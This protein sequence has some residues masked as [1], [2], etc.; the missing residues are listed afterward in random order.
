MPPLPPSTSRET[1][2]GSGR[3]LAEVRVRV[4]AVHKALWLWRDHDSRVYGLAYCSA[5]NDLDKML[6]SLYEV[7]L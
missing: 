6:D 2:A 3:S 5:S 4:R 7:V 1:S